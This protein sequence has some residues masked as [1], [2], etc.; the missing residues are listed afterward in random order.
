MPSGRRLGFE[1][2]RVDAP[3]ITLSV[4]AELEDADLRLDGVTIV[5]PGATPYQLGE[6]VIVVPLSDLLR[7]AS[8][9]EVGQLSRVCARQWRGGGAAVGSLPAMGT[10]A[11]AGHGLEQ[12]P[13]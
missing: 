11:V 2:K 5:Y 12:W 1:I 7:V 10:V 3:R 9:E 6:R 4:R 8:V 13:L